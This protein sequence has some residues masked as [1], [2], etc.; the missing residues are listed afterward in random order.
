MAHPDPHAAL[1]A[2]QPGAQT[3]RLWRIWMPVGLI[4]TVA[5]V[6]WALLTAPMPPEPIA[7]ALPPAPAAAAALPPVT[8]V[9]TENV[10]PCDSPEIA[11]LLA[12]GDDDAVVAAWG[13]GRAFRDAIVAGDADCISLNEPQRLWLVVNKRRSL[14]PQ[15]YA[16][17]PLAIPAAIR[18]G[19]GDYL[20]ADVTEALNQLSKAAQD[21]GHGEVVLG[22]GYRSHAVQVQNFQSH[23]DQ[24]GIAEAEAQSAR[25]GHSEHQT[26]LAADVLACESHCSG[27]L[28]FGDTATG[29][30]VADNGWRYGFIVRYDHGQQGITGY[31]PEPWHLRFVGKEL[32]RAYHEG[33]FTSLEKFFGLPDAPDYIDE[34]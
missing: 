7:A 25:P 2:R 17:K 20:R 12:S 3:A 27:I 31:E 14:E 15:N 9:Q 28:D 13:G 32:A 24:F 6:L 5:G 18:E 11:E 33:G 10:A 4:V 21:A 22:S 30:W 16:P 23:I 26:G 34:W 29:R 1:H 8:I 19:D